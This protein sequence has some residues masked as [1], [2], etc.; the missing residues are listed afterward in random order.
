VNKKFSAMFDR[1]LKALTFTGRNGHM[2]HFAFGK[3]ADI[4]RP[5]TV[6][7]ILS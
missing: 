1:V 4:V 7:N 3:I 6:S 2:R 5:E